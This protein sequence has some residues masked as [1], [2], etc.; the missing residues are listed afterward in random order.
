[1]QP[2]IW[3]PATG[4]LVYRAYS[5]QSLTPLGIVIAAITAVIH[6]IHPY[7][8]PFVLLCVFFLAGT[9]VTKV[10]K[11]VKAGLTLQST[12][13]SGGEGAR[14]HIQGT[15]SFHLKDRLLT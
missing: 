8:L 13:S 2:Y 5:H 9:R 6:G 3:V 1:M 7:P 11:D 15:W 10:K 12:G 4:L 14:T